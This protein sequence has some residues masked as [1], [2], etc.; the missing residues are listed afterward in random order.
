M[1]SPFKITHLQSA[2]QLIEAGDVKI[3]TDPWL[4]PGEYYGSWYHYPEISEEIVQALSYDY[5]YVSHIHPDHLSKKT[6]EILPKNAPVIIHAF[7]SPF[8]KRKIE[9]FGFTV[10]ELHHGI[11]M[12]LGKNTSISIYAADNCDP[13][14]CGKFLGC[15]V[16]ESKYKSSYIDTLMVMKSEG[17]IL[18]NTNDCPFEIAYKTL[19]TSNICKMPVDVLLVGYC[20]AGPFP[21]C[22]G[23]KEEKEKNLAAENKKLKF[24]DDACAYIN[25][26]KP[27]YYI[28]FAGTYIL[29]SRLFD[30]NLHR[31]NPTI[32]EAVTYI[33]EKI[34][35]A[36]IAL[37][38]YT[39]DVFDLKTGECKCN[40]FQ[41]DES[42]EEFKTRIQRMPLDFDL[43]KIDARHTR[44]LL[45]PAWE[46]F[47]A[48][49]NEIGLKSKSSIVVTTEKFSFCFD[50]ANP[51]EVHDLHYVP[52]NGYVRISLE[53]NLLHNLLKGPR[54]AHWN[55][56][57]I[58]S[59]L[60]FYRDPDIY[61]RGLYHCLCFFHL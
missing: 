33:S 3:L 46:R 7:D 16:A 9:S 34:S 56:A 60:R 25:L 31:G 48:K 8:L 55:N 24:L 17:H 28:P 11:E 6:F 40:Q 47:Q 58:G 29:G 21:Q 35:T 30:L 41:P 26:L 14:V 5:I 42:Y 32:S 45:T 43:E 23:F 53:H 39:F 10:V 37:P 1:K 27:T 15:S 57:E 20:G 13:T 44:E 19:T 50:L 36:S 22:F 12:K 59:H 54:F 61:E 52:S 18:V 38:M 49:A 51:P 4:T 2:T